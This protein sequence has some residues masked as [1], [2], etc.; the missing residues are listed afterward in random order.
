MSPDV[1]EIALLRTPLATA[2]K[3]GH[4]HVFAAL[5]SAI[6]T[7]NCLAAQSPA[8]LPQDVASSHSS[9]VSTSSPLA[10]TGKWA[11]GTTAQTSDPARP[12][13][14]CLAQAGTAFPLTASG[15]AACCYG[16]TFALVC[17]LGLF[18]LDRRH[19]RANDARLNGK[20]EGQLE[21]RTRIAQELHD[22]LLPGFFSAQL[23]VQAAL[24]RLPEDSQARVPLTRAGD[25]MRQALEEGRSA[26]EGLRLRQSLS[27]NLEQSLACLQQEIMDVRNSGHRPTFRVFSEGSRRALHPMIWNEAY[28]IAREASINAM[29]HSEAKHVEVEVVYRAQSL[30]ILVRDDGRGIDPEHLAIGRDGHWGLCGM[31]ERADRMGARLR[32]WSAPQR[33][34]ELELHIPGHLAYHRPGQADRSGRKYAKLSEA[35]Q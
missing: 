5:C 8:K 1:K 33:G 16:G 34:T 2:A 15:W 19:L 30:R 10:M 3:R 18:Y 17:L 24:D 32:L 4:R 23:Q 13:P 35:V 11:S 26:V 12:E 25:L 6:I 27:V 14:C 7:A 21:E 9:G 22:A 31:R 28:W 29:R 20:L